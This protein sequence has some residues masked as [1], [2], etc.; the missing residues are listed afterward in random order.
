MKTF[1]QR[2]GGLVLGILSGFDRLV[3]KGKLRQLY[4]P[5]GMNCY[6]SANHALYVDFRQHVESV[7]QQVLEASL[8]AQAKRRHRFEYLN[9]SQVSKE[10]VA[11]KYALQQQV[12][13][14][15]VCVLQCVEP[16]WSYDL[17]KKA[18]GKLTVV[19][20]PR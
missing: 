18:D 20:K 12:K 1:L 13:E 16:C 8:I 4:A 17:D 11:R 5:E 10:E 2:F 14:G 19:G 15:L 7:T 6:L 9:S 3:F